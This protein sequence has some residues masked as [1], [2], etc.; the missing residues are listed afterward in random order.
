M[1]SDRKRKKQARMQGLSEP[2]MAMFE[3]L[4]DVLERFRWLQ[5]LNHTQSYL[6]REKLKI[7]QD[8][9]G[10][11]AGGGDAHDRPG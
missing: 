1:A 5:V 3:L 9:L 2:E 6:L 11:R 4:E 7:S 8:E 10:P